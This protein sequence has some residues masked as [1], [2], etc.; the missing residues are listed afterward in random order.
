MQ[1][2]GEA[3]YVS[4]T[5]DTTTG[6]SRGTSLIVEARDALREADLHFANQLTFVVAK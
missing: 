3:E 4:G 6:S 1:E 5:A 2:L